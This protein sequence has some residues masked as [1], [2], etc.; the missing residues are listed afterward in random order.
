MTLL[1]FVI[2]LLVLLMLL[3][4]I[5]YFGWQIIGVQQ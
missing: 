2:Y 3:A 5:F 4:P 1:R